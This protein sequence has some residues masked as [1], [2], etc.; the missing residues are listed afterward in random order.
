[1]PRLY[2]RASS[3]VKPITILY[4]Q[5]FLSIIGNCPNP[6][7]HDT[8]PHDNRAFRGALPVPQRERMWQ[9][10]LALAARPGRPCH[11]A[12]SLVK[13]PFRGDCPR[14]F[15]LHHATWLRQSTT[16]P[17]RWP[18]SRSGALRLL[19]RPDAQSPT[20]GNVAGLWGEARAL[21]VRRR[22]AWRSTR[23]ASTRSGR[24]VA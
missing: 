15:H 24:R 11:I 2:H 10:R 12:E 22:C 9:G 3:P 13:L 18:V 20:R 17:R 6:A 7:A 4:S 23:R 5:E 14:H 19:A 21:A 16:R 8:P 1:M